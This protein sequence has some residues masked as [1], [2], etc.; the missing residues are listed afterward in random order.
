LSART[1]SARTATDGGLTL[2]PAGA[3]GAGNSGYLASVGTEITAWLAGAAGTAQ[4][5]NR[6]GPASL[7]LA[8]SGLTALAVAIRPSR[9]RALWA[10]S[11]VS[12]AAWC[13]GLAGAGARAPGPYTLPVAVAGLAIGWRVD[14]T[15][16]DARSWL[17][18]G[19]GVALLLLPSLVAVWSG[20]GWQ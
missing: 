16:Q 20:P 5:L 3:A 9:R 14:R 17:C 18:Y 11:A 19:P 12:R 4:C 13:V 2:L 6:P 1:P 15:R 7:A 8:I 10:G